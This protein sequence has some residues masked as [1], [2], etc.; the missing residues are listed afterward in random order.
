MGIVVLEFGTHTPAAAS[1][2]NRTRNGH[3]K[4]SRVVALA[5][6]LIVAVKIAAFSTRHSLS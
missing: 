5:L 4:E 2:A 6:E 3:E 1:V